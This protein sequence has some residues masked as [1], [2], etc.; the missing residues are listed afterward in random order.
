MVGPLPNTIDSLSLI[1]NPTPKYA[2]LDPI[3]SPPLNGLIPLPDLVE[4]LN[5]Q[6]TFIHLTDPNFSDRISLRN[7]ISSA[8]ED[9]WF[10]N[11]SD[12]LYSGDPPSCFEPISLGSLPPLSDSGDDPGYRSDDYSSSDEANQEMAWLANKNSY[13]ALIVPMAVYKNGNSS[14]R[15]YRIELC[16]ED[17]SGINLMLDWDGI[18]SPADQ[19]H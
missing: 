17:S 5:P 6:A 2:H 10:G 19:F 3:S 14:N 15:D 1:S 16:I 12:N 9:P 8:S 13:S 18:S 11:P 4:D 7:N